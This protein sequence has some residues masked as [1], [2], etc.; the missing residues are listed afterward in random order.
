MAK[1]KKKRSFST[2]CANYTGPAA[3]MEVDFTVKISKNLQIS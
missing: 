2:V 3:G 1:I